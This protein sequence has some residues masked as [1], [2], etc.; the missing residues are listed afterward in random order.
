MNLFYFWE[1]FLFTFHDG[2]QNVKNKLLKI[3]KLGYWIYRFKFTCCS[4]INS[5]FVFRS[6]FYLFYWGLVRLEN[7]SLLFGES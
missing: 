1:I 6:T 7:S 5:F 3:I 4:C 2:C